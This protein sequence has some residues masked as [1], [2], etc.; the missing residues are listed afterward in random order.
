M[1]F[2]YPHKNIFAYGQT[3]EGREKTEPQCGVE[4][5]SGTAFLLEIFPNGADNELT[6]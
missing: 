6:H 3:L 5:G 2:F 4:V 1:W